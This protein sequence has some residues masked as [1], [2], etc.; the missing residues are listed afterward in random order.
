MGILVLFTYVYNTYILRNYI[1][2]KYGKKCYIEGE[3]NKNI[4]YPIKFD[5]LSDCIDYI[6]NK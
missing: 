6:E 4:R 2:G 5:T 3:E 1:A